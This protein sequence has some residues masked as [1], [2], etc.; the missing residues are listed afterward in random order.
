M[1]TN[2]PWP[3]S[4]SLL[5]LGIQYSRPWKRDE[6][7]GEFASEATQVYPVRSSKNLPLA[8]KKMAS[9]WRPVLL[10]RELVVNDGAKASLTSVVIRSLLPIADQSSFW[11]GEFSEGDIHCS[12]KKTRG[13]KKGRRSPGKSAWVERIQLRNLP[14]SR[15]GVKKNQ[16]ALISHELLFMLT[17]D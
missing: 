12:S 6:F 15:T 5:D 9:S 13:G 3:K 10:Q 1:L 14:G 16:K 4:A 7:L 8:R 17:P 2:M 11:K